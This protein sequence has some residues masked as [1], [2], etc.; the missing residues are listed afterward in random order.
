MKY[1]ARLFPVSGSVYLNGPRSPLSELGVRT[2]PLVGSSD[3]LRRLPLRGPTRICDETGDDASCSP[4]RNGHQRPS[5]KAVHSN[6]GNVPA[7]V[8]S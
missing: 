6:A 8:S 3:P 2:T 4:F 5:L 7:L 1:R